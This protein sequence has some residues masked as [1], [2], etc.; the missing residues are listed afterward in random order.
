M[1]KVLR[2]SD[3][4]DGGMPGSWVLAPN[5]EAGSREMSQ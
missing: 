3:P 1:S 5:V 4:R 2:S